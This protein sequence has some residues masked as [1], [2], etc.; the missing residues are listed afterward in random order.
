MSLLSLKKEFL[1]PRSLWSIINFLID[2]FWDG[3]LTEEDSISSLANMVRTAAAGDDSN[4]D[5]IASMSDKEMILI[6][7][8]QGK[9]MP[10][11]FETRDMRY[12]GKNRSAD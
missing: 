3:L 12:E 8:F 4:S 5:M 2:E 7:L 9:E 1:L 11:K 10:V 6:H